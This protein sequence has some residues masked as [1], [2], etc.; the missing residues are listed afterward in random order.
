MSR[1]KNDKYMLREKDHING[2]VEAKLIFINHVIGPGEDC[3]W[4]VFYMCV[5]SCV[6]PYNVFWVISCVV[7]SVL[8]IMVLIV[9]INSKA[10]LWLCGM[11][12]LGIQPFSHNSLRLLRT[13]F[14]KLHRSFSPPFLEKDN[15]LLTHGF[16]KV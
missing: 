6:V 4:T 14:S 3:S 15:N 12:R 2:L 11:G 16:S 9:S 5:N 13:M 7:C 10:C 1:N 8:W